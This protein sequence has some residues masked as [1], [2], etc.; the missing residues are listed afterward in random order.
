MARIG[1]DARLTYY[2]QGG[3]SQ[4]AQHLIREFA[5]L[6]T[7]HQFMLLQ[8]YKDERVLAS[9]TNQQRAR[10][11]T[12]A[13]HRFERKALAAELFPRRLSLLHSP[14][15]IP[16]VNCG[17]KRVITVH[18]LAFL[19]Y[20]EFLT[21]ESRRY[22]NDQ[23][24]TAVREADH[25][26][27][28]SESTRRDMLD[29]L[30][31]APAKVSVVLEAASS[32]FQQLPDE[33]VFPVLKRYNLPDNYIL[34]VGTIEPRKNI[35]ALLEAYAQLV[36]QDPDTPAL[37]I[38]GRRGWLYDRVIEVYDRLDLG[39][40]VIWLEEFGW[41]DLP[42]IYNGAS[43]FCLPS[44]Y[45]GFGLP[46]LEAMACG[47]PVIVS[48]R[49]SLPEVVGDAGVVIDPADIDALCAAMRQILSDQDFADDL[50][51]RG[52]ARAQSFSWRRAALETLVV[53]DSV[54]DI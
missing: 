15:F 18:D 40:R 9:G 2:T 50:R 19:H 1:I 7:A 54:L 37:V 38:A 31:V 26:I 11:F 51:Q 41:A 28:V 17:F 23:I 21:A 35:P 14:D 52:L 32:Q 45:E 5:E 13:H 48:D 29:L 22:Y 43:L 49:A 33:R 53:Y 27:T 44:N 10:C 24:G 6:H 25:I 47:T 30:G 8:S 46:P 20:P 3:I 12:P 34:F 42:A 4:Y 36:V 16:P 39:S